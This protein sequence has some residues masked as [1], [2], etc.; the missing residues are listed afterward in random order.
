M[1]TSI[2]SHCDLQA[3]R[4]GS[5]HFLRL[6]AEMRFEVYRL[7]VLEEGL[8]LLAVP[9]VIIRTDAISANPARMIR[10]QPKPH[11]EASLGNRGLLQTCRQIH[12]E[13]LT[14]LYTK[15]SFFVESWLQLRF[16][17]EDIQFKRIIPELRAL[18]VLDSFHVRRHAC[19][20]EPV[21]KGLKEI[22]M[23]YD[24]FICGHR[25]SLRAFKKYA[26]QLIRANPSS[27]AYL[28]EQRQV[29]SK[30]WDQS[31]GR[32]FIKIV[33]SGDDFPRDLGVNVALR[34]TGRSVIETQRSVSLPVQHLRFDRRRSS[35]RLDILVVSDQL[36]S[37]LFVIDRSHDAETYD[38]RNSC[39][40]SVPKHE[41]NQCGKKSR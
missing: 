25:S 10:D 41:L 24:H 8:V 14:V 6:P 4:H 28:Y 1:P 16:I 29:Q 34:R 5:F 35:A 18:T 17:L 22:T 33:T 38:M 40:R 37:C 11:P 27:R 19:F 39:N 26:A 31:P 32:W 23:V 2:T 21:L 30:Q 36:A 12:E 20:E 15:N 3:A 7:L 9:P 13:A